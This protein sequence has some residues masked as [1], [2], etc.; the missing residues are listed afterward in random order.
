MLQTVLQL[1]CFTNEECRILRLCEV[2]NVGYPQR[3]H[4]SFSDTTQDV[5]QKHVDPHRNTGFP[6]TACMPKKLGLILNKEHA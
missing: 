6:L 2:I 3:L 5:S 1:S 4:R